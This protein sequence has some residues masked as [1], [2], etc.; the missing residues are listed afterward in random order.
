MK[1]FTFVTHKRREHMSAELLAENKKELNVFRSAADFTS[2]AFKM[3][4]EEE[5][6][7]E[8]MLQKQQEEKRRA[9]AAKQ[10]ENRRKLSVMTD[11]GDGLDSDSSSDSEDNSDSETDSG[12]EALLMEKKEKAAKEKQVQQ[13]VQEK[14]AEIDEDLPEWRR[15]TLAP[16]PVSDITE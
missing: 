10:K 8:A 3:K 5:E 12:S 2:A 14:K 11:F 9:A 7:E 1:G 15:Y 16:P 6:L 13:A 4:S